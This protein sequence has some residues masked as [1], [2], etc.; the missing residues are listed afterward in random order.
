MRFPN[1]ACTFSQTGGLQRAMAKEI[2]CVLV[3]TGKNHKD[4]SFLYP[5]FE[6]FL[7]D[8]LLDE[9]SLHRCVEQRWQRLRNWG[10]CSTLMDWGSGEVEACGSPYR[11]EEL[12][13]EAPSSLPFHRQRREERETDISSTHGRRCWKTIDS[14]FR[15]AKKCSLLLC[16]S[17]NPKPSLH[18]HFNGL[19]QR[20]LWIGL[21]YPWR[22]YILV[23]VL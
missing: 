20:S 13:P 16:T 4:S 11:W 1:P 18:S 9:G 10:L 17:R 8:L 22:F 2:I 6:I 14:K 15:V 3:E 7:C 5:T 19:F 21:F 23:Y 12:I